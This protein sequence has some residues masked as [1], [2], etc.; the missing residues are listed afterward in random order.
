MVL[1]GCSLSS[2]CCWDCHD[3]LPYLL[4]LFLSTAQISNLV[5]CCSRI[6]KCLP[7]STLLINSL[8]FL[9]NFWVFFLILRQK[10][11]VFHALSLL[12]SFISCVLSIV[13]RHSYNNILPALC[14]ISLALFLFMVVFKLN[15]DQYYI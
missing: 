8:H 10:I 12:S 14:M 11:Q 9:S 7:S 13:V 3:H 15:S 1:M 2:Y 6:L 5:L 4:L